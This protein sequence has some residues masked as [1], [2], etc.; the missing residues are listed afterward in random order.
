[1]IVSDIGIE[2]IAL[3]SQYQYTYFPWPTGLYQL[4]LAGRKVLT[5]LF[6]SSPMIGS[7]L[8]GRV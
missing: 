3:E 1:M 5:T 6:L 2:E 8:A 7:I 4:F